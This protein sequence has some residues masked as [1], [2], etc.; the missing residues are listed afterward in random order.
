MR[1]RREREHYTLFIGSSLSS[2]PSVIFGCFCWEHHCLW[3][4]MVLLVLMW[5]MLV[6]VS[7]CLRRAPSFSPCSWSTTAQSPLSIETLS[8]I[9]SP[10]SSASSLESS[11]FRY[12]L[13]PTCVHVYPMYI[14]SRAQAC[15]YSAPM[16][17]ST[18][19]LQYSSGHPGV[20]P[21]SCLT[22]LS[23]LFASLDS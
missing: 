2:E 11:S 23:S 5:P 18:T 15:S 9:S 8:P 21:Y 13:P 19:A 4:W 22:L 1:N 6:C 17:L 12:Y 3:W 20:S 14:F 10:S 7:S 16:G